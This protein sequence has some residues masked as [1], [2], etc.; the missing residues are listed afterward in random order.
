MLRF[1]EIVLQKLEKNGGFDIKQ[2]YGREKDH[3]IGFK[4][5]VC[6]K[7]AKSP[8]IVITTLTPGKYKNLASGEST[9]NYS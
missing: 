9:L 6:R 3:Y 7:M 4:E 1:L 8:K 2:L 5:N